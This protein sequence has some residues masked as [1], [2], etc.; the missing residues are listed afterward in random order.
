MTGLVR[1]GNL[2][3]IVYRAGSGLSGRAGPADLQFAFAGAQAEPGS[4]VLHAE[5]GEVESVSEPGEALCPLDG[6]ERHRQKVVSGPAERLRGAVGEH[7][8]VPV[9]RGRSAENGA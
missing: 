5:T 6:I 3:E 1:G 9:H 4:S 2:T 8:A 7:V